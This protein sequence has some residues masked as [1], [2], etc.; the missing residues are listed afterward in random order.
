MACGCPVICSNVASM[1]EAAGNA[2][3]YID[4]LDVDS[5]VHAIE[6]LVPDTQGRQTLKPP[7]WPGPVSSHG[8]RRPGR[9]WI[10]FNA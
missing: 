8:K 3:L 10:S 1:P 2:A 4:P 6:T 7:A 5:L 9:P